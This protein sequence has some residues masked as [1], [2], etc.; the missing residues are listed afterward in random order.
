MRLPVSLDPRRA[1]AFATN[2]L[3]AARHDASLTPSSISWTHFARVLKTSGKAPRTAKVSKATKKTAKPKRKA[4]HRGTVEGNIGQGVGIL[5][6]R[7]C[8][9]S[10]RQF[11][12]GHHQT[13][14]QLAQWPGPTGERPARRPG[15]NGSAAVPGS[16]ALF[17][18]APDM[19]D[20]LI[21]SGLARSASV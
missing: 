18:W 11:L 4:E 10:C 14:V 6:R 7:L 16:T 19:L 2:R 12:A 17:G 13:L 1:E 8:I 21:T 20:E 3:S 15:C 9:L 5:R